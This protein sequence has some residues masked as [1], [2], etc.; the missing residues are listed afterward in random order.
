MGSRGTRISGYQYLAQPAPK[1]QRDSDDELEIG[2]IHRG[3]S[4]DSC[5]EEPILGIRY[6]CKDCEGEN[7]LDLCSRC[8]GIGFSNSINLLTRCTH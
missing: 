3:F 1:N 5:G 2:Q 8:E 7:S 4:C 6:N